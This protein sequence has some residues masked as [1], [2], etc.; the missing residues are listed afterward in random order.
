MAEAQRATYLV[1]QNRHEEAVAD[2]TAALQV[3]GADT[4]V[5]TPRR[6]PVGRWSAGRPYF[7]SEHAHQLDTR[8]AEAYEAVARKEGEREV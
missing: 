8:R 6:R 1:Q 5:L 4:P 7:G 2:Y 3:V